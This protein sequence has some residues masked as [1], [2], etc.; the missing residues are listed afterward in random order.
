MEVKKEFKACG[1]REGGGDTIRQKPRGE[2]LCSSLREMYMDE[3]MPDLAVHP[4][5]QL[6][7]NIICAAK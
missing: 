7:C 3:K 5:R 6:S 1:V 2:T 4:D